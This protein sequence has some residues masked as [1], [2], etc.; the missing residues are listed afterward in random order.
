MWVGVA[1]LAAVAVALSAAAAAAYAY[2]TPPPR[3]PNVESAG[4]RAARLARDRTALGLVEERQRQRE[5]EQER[6]LP[7]DAA[8]PLLPPGP[9]L[10]PSVLSSATAA[11][12][13]VKEKDDD[14]GLP[15]CPAVTLVWQDLSYFVPM[16]AAATAAAKKKDKA[17][18]KKAEGGGVGASG[19]HGDKLPTT[20]KQAA[21]SADDSE[22]QLLHSLTGFARPGDLV[23]LMG[24]SGAGKSTLMDVLAQRKTVGRVAG[25]VSVDGFPA[26]AATWPRVH[27]YCEQMDVHSPGQLVEEALVTSASLRLPRGTTRRAVQRSVDEALKMVDLDALR[28]SPVGDATGAGGAGLT[29]EQRKRLTIAVEL[30]ARPSVVFM[31]EPTSGL[32][33]RAAAVVMRGVRNVA[34]A[35]RAVVVTIHQPSAEIFEAF[36]RLYLMHRG[37]RCDFFGDLG[38]ES[39]ELVAYLRAAAV[40][41]GRPPRMVGAAAGGGGGAAGGHDDVGGGGGDQDDD[42]DLGAPAALPP[43]ADGL[44]P[45]TWMLD[46]TA[47][48]RGDFWPGAYARSDLCAANAAEASA[49]VRGARE[50][51]GARPLSVAGLTRGGY[52]Q[53]LSRQTAALVLKFAQVYWRTPAYNATRLVLALGLALLYG[54]MYFGQGGGREAK[55]AADAAAAAAAAGDAPG[56][57]GAPIFTMTPGQ[58]QGIMGMLFNSATMMGAINMSCVRATAAGNER[59]T[60]AATAPAPATRARP[61][62]SSRYFL[63]RRRA[64]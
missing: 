20:N 39:R 36:D 18:K 31:D 43:L 61:P 51:P 53:P 22:L 35:G 15:A 17:K 2:A 3:V 32:D 4:Q 40:A 5:R 19:K 63:S 27:G 8:R 13:G 52:A 38:A 26:D 44:N 57:A 60:V 1:Y 12:N 21:A 9:S 62:L 59:P 45:A 24:G 11:S 47:K 29:V 16:P 23:A 7:P 50:A 46:V 33:A 37:G 14:D 58:I 42:D 56:G 55:A 34:R 48:G 30:V 41:P 49:L 28:G 25:T 6:G 54:I 64:P 10:A